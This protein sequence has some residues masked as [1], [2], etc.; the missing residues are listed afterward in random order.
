MKATFN[1]CYRAFSASLLSL[2]GF[3]ACS[4]SI[5]EDFRAELLYGT[6]TSNYQVKGHVTAEDGTPIEGI[7]AVLSMDENYKVDSAYT[8]S[9]GDFAIKERGIGGSI[10]SYKKKGKLKVILKDEDGEAHG[11]EFATDTIKSEDITI[12]QVK[13]GDN[14]WNLGSYEVTANGKMKKK[15]KK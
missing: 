11:G 7:K 13:S 3:S 5:K 8:N 2:L 15:S 9:K 14:T 1:H 10:E 6:P 12:K 4:D